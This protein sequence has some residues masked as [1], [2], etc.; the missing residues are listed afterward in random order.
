MRRNFINA[1][2]VV[3]VL[4]QVAIAPLGVSKGNDGIS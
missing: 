1:L 4:L 3:M 2:M